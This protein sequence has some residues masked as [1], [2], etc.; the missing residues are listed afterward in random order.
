VYAALAVFVHRRSDAISLPASLAILI[1]FAGAVLAK[2][3]AVVLP[4]L[5]LATD[6]FW[7][8]GSA[9]AAIRRN[10]RLYVPLAV[11]ASLGL[12]RVWGVLAAA[13][14]AGFSLPDL[15]WH[16]YFWTQCRAV[17]VYVRLFFAPYGQSADHDF[18]I[19]RSPL[20]PGVAIA[21]AGLVLAVLA[22]WRLRRALPLASYGVFVFLLLLSPTS[23]VVPIADPLVER[24]LYLPSLGLLLV[25]VEA[26]R[27]WNPQPRA[28]VGALASVLVAAGIATH[29][30]AAVWASPLALWEDTVRKSPENARARFQLGFAY[31]E[32]GRCDDALREY[33]TAARLEPA[34]H[35]LLVDWALACDCAGRP[36]DALAKLGE[37]AS[38]EATGHVYSLIGMIHGKQGRR[39]EAFAALARAESLDPLFPMT[40]VYRGHL[41]AL[42]GEDAQAAAA[43]RRALEL[44]P[45]LGLARD[46]LAAADERLRL[47]G[48][49]P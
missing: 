25:V 11:L 20:D 36:A 4:A 39:A 24:R 18:A 37:A 35:G 5:L 6:A 14:S 40:H 8:R 10:W 3:H 9:A 13:D 49:L 1:L 21:L 30:R 31:Y 43:Y 44:D 19:S 7:A 15:A 47:A 16:D 34:G 22:A 46:A 42:A 45:R 12:W 27:H 38:L 2:E 23:S 41:H 33:E 17:W 32:V 48:S 28:L 29:Q 26:L